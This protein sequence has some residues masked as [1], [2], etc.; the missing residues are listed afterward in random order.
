M[1][2]LPATILFQFH[3]A[4][5]VTHF[6]CIFFCYVSWTQSGVIYP[7]IFYDAGWPVIE[8]RPTKGPL[9]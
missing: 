1:Q 9:E 3:R 4:H 5:V 6:Y 8:V 2:K 7:T